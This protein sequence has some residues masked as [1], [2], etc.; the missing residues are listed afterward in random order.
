M[1]LGKYIIMKKIKNFLSAKNIAE[2]KKKSYLIL[3]LYLL[4][5]NLIN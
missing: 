3:L 2:K 1:K 5:I 4:I